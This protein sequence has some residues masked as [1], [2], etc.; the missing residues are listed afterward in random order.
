M[1]PKK[2][3]IKDIAKLARTSRGTVD[4]Y[5][6]GRGK[7]SPE[8][9]KRIEAAIQEAGY[10][11]NLAAR[12]L[13][14]SMNSMAVGVIL[15]NVGNTFFD[16]IKQGIDDEY[17]R[18]KDSG[19][20]LIYKKVALFDK[21]GILKAIE[22]LKEEGIKA[23]LITSFEDDDIVK[24]VD[25]LGVVTVALNIDL[26]LKNKI[27]YV[28][29]DY[30]NSGRLSAN[31]AN[32]I[33]PSGKALIVLG[34]YAHTGQKER[35]EGFKDGLKPTIEIEGAVENKDD[36]KISYKAVSEYLEKNAVDLVYFSGGGVKGGLKAVK[37]S[38]QRPLVV[39]VDESDAT[40]AGLKSGAVAGSVVQ[41][42]FTQG[43][44]AMQDIYDCL[45]RRKAVKPN[46][47]VENSVILKESMIPHKIEDT[48]EVS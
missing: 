35:V 2:V 1:A 48:K 43:R 15:A 25:D 24:A 45:L 4:R 16:L 22:E 10:T 31:F 19:V 36:D 30:R 8:V 39:T 38:D 46:R 47:I 5:L 41:H 40:M 29:P 17:Q 21:E 23:L 44:L 26:P 37:D 18:N 28:G 33:L 20:H 9:A 32:L 3:T 13:H 27:A 7:V 6:N 34:G 14:Y 11:P 12:S 42:P